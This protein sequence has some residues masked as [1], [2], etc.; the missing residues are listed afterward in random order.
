[1]SIQKQI[2]KIYIHPDTGPITQ[3]D[4]DVTTIR[5]E[6]YRAPSHVSQDEIAIREI[7]RQI[8]CRFPKVD[9]GSNRRQ[10][11]SLLGRLSVA[12]AFNGVV[13]LLH[14]TIDAA[15]STSVVNVQ[16]ELEQAAEVISQL[17]SKL[18]KERKELEALKV[19]AYS[20]ENENRRLKALSEKEH[21]DLALIR[22]RM[23]QMKLEVQRAQMEVE[24]SRAEINRLEQNE[25]SLTIR[26]ENA[27]KEVREQPAQASPD[28]QAELA[29][30]RHEK[31]SA[32][33]I[34]KQL[35]ATI[36]SQEKMIIQ[37]EERM[38]SIVENDAPVEYGIPV[39]DNYNL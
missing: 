3:M 5:E 32:T 18:E 8:H 19:R 6:I 38:R 22:P 2:I 14:G 35:R 34:E 12:D 27:Q 28:Q 10:L 21:Q 39:G 30:L 16:Q 7:A 13:I 9:T 20:H 1:M 37:L 36:A 29:K 17:K 24:H 26:L 25:A 23:E 4:L 15:A 31:R 33:A 11:A